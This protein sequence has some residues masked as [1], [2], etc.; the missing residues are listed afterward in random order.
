[1]SERIRLSDEK[2]ARMKTPLPH[3][4]EI[5]LREFLQPMGITQSAFAAHIGVDRSVVTAIVKGRR[6]VTMDMAFKF[7]AAF[8]TSAAFWA[9]MQH[10]HD[11]S[12]AYIEERHEK[13]FAKIT[14][15][16]LAASGTHQ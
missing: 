7:A 4:G 14:R 5:L 13:K 16:E 12:K 3:P 15:F 2:Y 10:N 11:V 8:G 9:N 1:M 6:S